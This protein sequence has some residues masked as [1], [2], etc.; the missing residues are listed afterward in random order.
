MCVCS[1]IFGRILRTFC[2][3]IR[4]I[5]ICMVY[6]IMSC[7]C[8]ACVYVHAW[9]R[10]LR[11]CIHLFLD[12]FSDIRTYSYSYIMRVCMRMITVRAWTW[13]D[14][15]TAHPKFHGRFNLCDRIF[16]K[17]YPSP[18]RLKLFLIEYSVLSSSQNWIGLNRLRTQCIQAEICGSSYDYSERIL[19]LSRIGIWQWYVI[20]ANRWTPSV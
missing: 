17:C 12:R 5:A 1:L 3:N 13:W 18:N 6:I 9:V 20:I 8:T 4:V 19:K 14:L 15:T 11:I 7:S 10:T 16:S 2:E